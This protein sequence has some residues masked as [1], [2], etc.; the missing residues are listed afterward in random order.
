M[1]FVRTERF[2]AETEEQLP[3]VV[4]SLMEAMKFPLILMQGQLGAG[5]TTLVKEILRQKGC[6]DTGTS[7]SYSLINQYGSGDE[8]FYHIDLYRLERPEEA[9]NLGIEEFIYSGALCMIEWPELIMEHI[10]KPFEIIQIEVAPD[11]GRSIS[12]IHQEA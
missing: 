12:I 7:P 3:E 10:D 6:Q 9:F 1:S 8:I 11:G 2:I 4:S 5:K